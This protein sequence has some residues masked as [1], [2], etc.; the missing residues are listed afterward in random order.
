M[1]QSK[2]LTNNLKDSLI[3]LKRM[4]LVFHLNNM[5]INVKDMALI[6]IVDILQKF[7]IKVTIDTKF[8]NETFK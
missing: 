3:D 2:I 1:I 8:Y 5:T 6:I 4:I 7:Q